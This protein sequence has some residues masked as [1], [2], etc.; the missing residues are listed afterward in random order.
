MT[1]FIED[2]RIEKGEKMKKIEIYD[3]T[4]RDGSQGEGIFFTLQ[5]KIKIAEVL[6]DFGIDFIEGGWPGSNPKDIK[7]FEK[8]KKIKLKNSKIVAFGST[9]RKKYTPEKDPLLKKLLESET[10][11]ITIFGKS[12]NLHVTD[13]LKISLDENLKII[14]DS[15]NFLVKKGRRVFFDA[16]HFFDGYK[17][18]PEYALKTI[19]I[20]EQAGAERII[21]CD[22]NGGSL[23]FEVEKIIKD[24]KKKVNVPLGI[25]AHNDSGVAVAN[26][27]IAVKEGC[28]QVHG[29]INGIGERCGNADLTTIIPIL[30]IKMGYK[31][32]EKEKLASLTEVSRKIFEFA[33]MIPSTNQPFVG[34]SAF[35]HK[36]G[37]HIDAVSKKTEAY[38]HI[39]PVIVGNERK[40]LVSELSGKSTVLQKLK[41]YEIEKKPEVV[42]KILDMVG[43]LENEGYQFE[44]A[45]GTFELMVSKSLGKFKEFFEVEGFRVIVE[46]RGRK[47][48]SEATVKVKVDNLVELTASEGNGPVNALDNALRKALEKIYPEIKNLKL[49]DYRVRILHPEKAT[50]ALTR[51][52]IQSVDEKD[53]WGTIGVS[54]NI[55]EASWN[56]LIDSFEYKLYKDKLKKTINKK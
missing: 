4:L 28:I 35:A 43:E 51:V 12:W 8:I 10:E 39:N 37:I 16:E 55:I 27:I 32:I 42:K 23:P 20:A 56:A 54:P 36:G 2:S 19:M 24:V 38:E 5:D 13:I 9:R 30:Q 14:E 11:Y 44:S 1:E 33:N 22:T 29:T 6:D 40:L 17:R 50:G 46:K 3:T 47:V 34:L 18:N 25:H 41:G 26:S 49:T 15:I 45:E 48:I 31:C 53:N 52:I 7:F 21:L